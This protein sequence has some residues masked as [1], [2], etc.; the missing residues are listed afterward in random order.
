MPQG[1]SLKSVKFISSSI[2]WAVGNYGTILKTTDGGQNWIIQASQTFDY[3]ESVSFTN[4][5]NGTAV[6]IGHDSS[7]YDVG[8]II[9]TIDGGTTW[10]LQPSGTTNDLYGVCFTDVNNGTAV[11]DLEQF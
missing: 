3:L 7:G 5:D 1:N 10:N 11:G 9:Y 4:A 6:G 8:I 2:G